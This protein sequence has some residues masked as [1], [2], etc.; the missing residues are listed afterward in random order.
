MVIIAM[1]ADD[2]QHIHPD[3]YHYALDI[4]MSDITIVP[5]KFSKNC[6]ALK[7]FLCS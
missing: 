7:M 5:S 2:G 3:F 4:Y 1:R 6:N